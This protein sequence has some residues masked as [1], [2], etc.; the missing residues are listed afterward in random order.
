MLAYLVFVIPITWHFF[1]SD[2]RKSPERSSPA[3]DD[4][5][6]EGSLVA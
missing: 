3:D 2:P 4:A 6:A 1:R 5:T